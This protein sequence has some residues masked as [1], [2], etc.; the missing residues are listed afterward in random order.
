LYPGGFLEWY[1][2]FRPA[3]ADGIKPGYIVWINSLMVGACILPVYFG[4]G[5]H[6]GIN[7]WYCISA[8]AAVKACFLILGVFVL[9]KY[10][11]GVVTGLLLYIPLFVWQL[12]FAFIG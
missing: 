9:E 7:V 8:I 11:P 1:K 5:P 4:G 6:G 2:E 3:L 12:V 10:P